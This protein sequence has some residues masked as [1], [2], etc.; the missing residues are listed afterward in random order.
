MKKSFAWFLILI[1]SVSSCSVLPLVQASS[2]EIIK[3]LPVPYMYQ[4]T[5][6][7][8]FLNCLSMVMQYYGIK[9]HAWDLAQTWNLG[10]DEGTGSI[11]QEIIEHKVKEFVESKGLTVDTPCVKGTWNFNFYKTHIDLGEPVILVGYSTA[12]QIIPTGGHAVVITGYKSNSTGDYLLI[13]DPSGYFVKDQWGEWTETKY[14]YMYA[15]APWTKVQ[16]YFMNLFNLFFMYDIV[17]HGSPQP[18][19]GVLYLTDS[20][21]WHGRPF[22]LNNR[23]TWIIDGEIYLNN[24]LTWIVDGAGGGQEILPYEDLKIAL[25]IANQYESSFSYQ[26]NIQLISAITG[27]SVPLPNSAR[28]VSVNGYNVL[29]VAMTIR[30]STLRN[31]EP[32]AYYLYIG[33]WKPNPNYS[34][35]KPYDVIGPVKIEIASG[36]DKKV[37]E[38]FKEVRV[39]P[40]GGIRGI[41][42]KAEIKANVYSYSHVNSKGWSWTLYA[43][44]YM[45][46]IKGLFM[47]C[48]EYKD[49]GLTPLEF[50]V[51]AY[52]PQGKQIY[53]SGWITT[54][55]DG[56]NCYGD[57]SHLGGEVARVQSPIYSL[58]N[59][60]D[61]IILKTKWRIYDEFWYPLPGFWLES[62]EIETAVLQ[63]KYSARILNPTTSKPSNVGDP[64]NPSSVM[65]AV[66]VLGPLPI[67]ENAFNIKI[68]GKEAS[69]KA[70][71]L[72]QRVPELFVF[73]VSPPTQATEGKYDLEISLSNKGL[74]TSCIE[75]G[76]IIYTTA[77]SVEPIEQGLAWLRS[78]QNDDGSWTYFGRKNVGLTSLCALAFLNNAIL[79]DDVKKALDWILSQRKDE[80]SITAGPG[81]W[82]YRED[83]RVYDTSMAILALVAAKGLGYSPE[84]VDLDEVISK[85]V[86][87]LLRCQC[88][89]QSFDG[90]NYSY[91]D[92]NYGGWGYPRYHWADL[93]NTQFAVLALDQAVSAGI[94]TIDSK[95]WEDVAIFT[96]RCLSDPDYNPKW[97]KSTDKGFKY[98]PTDSRSRGSMAGAGIWTLG[99]C[100]LHGV[101]SVKVDGVTVS[102]DDAINDGLAWLDQFGYVDQNYPIGKTWYYYYL[103]SVA[104]GYVIVGQGEDWYEDMVQQLTSIQASDGHWPSY[105]SEEPSIL[106][107][108]EAIL[109]IQTRAIP[110][111]P[112]NLRYLSFSLYSNAL[113]R[114]TDPLGR[115]VGYNYI[116]QKGENNIPTAVYS[117]PFKEPQY[118]VIVEPEPGTYSVELIGMS[119]GQYTLYIQ[120]YYGSDLTKAYEFTKG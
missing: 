26:V 65:V 23:F 80:G 2:S 31:L 44:A 112:E 92:F 118:V 38:I 69:F 54:D 86:D 97:Y 85:A 102:L 73:E 100:K 9:I 79:D 114:I 62:E 34:S 15:I 74:F 99:L 98:R 84:N 63:L 8:C 90:Y 56:D 101:I 111:K 18:P 78:T 12:L 4:G 5:T 55:T 29:N 109:A 108:A 87:F 25:D 76:A 82:P 83:V 22:Y 51:N 16:E 33:L 7:W 49:T 52:N 50:K 77:P 39:T 61:Y 68:G 88:V 48:R 42:G 64:N 89:G 14:P 6:G 119:E 103:L 81:G 36:Y 27:E 117:G 37:L 72:T 66:E 11:L 95:V 13:H 115:T 40:A 20:S 21:I 116:T 67:P 41:C 19:L 17:I 45:R 120:G 70:V 93:S 46:W 10:H 60:P 3:K 53:S 71:E 107:T 113:F 91:D 110:M 1:V 58:T 47:E 94:S 104:K 105:Y 59:M 96:I 35:D 32:G 24:R 43:D 30:S 28:I 57:Y 75:K 106:A